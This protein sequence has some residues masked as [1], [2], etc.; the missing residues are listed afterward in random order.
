MPRLLFVAAH[1]LRRELHSGGDVLFAHVAREIARQRPDWDLAVL[2][3]AYAADTFAQFFSTVLA[4]PATDDEPERLQRAPYRILDTW[5]RRIGPTTKLGRHFGPQLV[6]ATGDF[7]SDVVPADRLRR[8]SQVLWTGVVHHLNPPPLARHNSFVP[9]TVSYALQQLSLR[10][11]RRGC[12]RVFLLNESVREALEDIGFQSNALSVLGAGIDMQRF[13]LGPSPPA[14]D[15]LLWVHR[16]EPTKGVFDLPKLMAALPSTVQLDV[17][18]DG[19]AGVRRRLEGALNAADRARVTFHTFLDAATLQD[20]YSR[21]NAFI[22]CSYEEGWGLS[23]CEALATGTPCVAYDL[24]S[25]AQTFRGLVETVP[26]GD[27]AA[28]A[29]RVLQVLRHPDGESARD[30]RRAAVEQ[31]SFA[32]VAARQAKAFDELLARG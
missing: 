17:V 27:V 7:I 31:Y 15:R 4:L 24:P 19:P 20:L 18:G 16:L 28:L 6:H 29:R 25:Y 12:D 13:A 8:Q 22:S 11:L 9:A 30:R 1:V 2:V 3:P 26:V 5:L 21:A 14:R 32:G 23:L 10:V